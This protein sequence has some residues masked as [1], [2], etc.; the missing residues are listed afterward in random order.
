PEHARNKGETF[1][2]FL[3]SC[4]YNS[5]DLVN[6]ENQL[7]TFFELSFAFNA[8]SMPE[9][10][11]RKRGVDPEKARK[12]G[13]FNGLRLLGLN[14]AQ[15]E[16]LNEA[17][18]G[19]QTIEDAP[20]LKPEH[21]AVFDCANKC[22]KLGERFIATEGHIRMMAAAQPFVS[23]AISK[24]INLP[25][26][27]SVEDVASAYRLSWELGLKANALYRDGSKLSQPLSSK[28]DTEAEADEETAVEAA[29]GEASTEAAG[30]SATLM[31]STSSAFAT[32][33]LAPGMASPA[34]GR[35]SG[36]PDPQS[37][38][39]SPQSPSSPEPSYIERIIEKIVE[40][41]LRQRLPDTRRSI[42]HRF[43]VAGHE[44][45]LTVG[46]YDDGRPGE[47]FITMSKEG[48]TI[49]GLMDSLGTAIS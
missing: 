16:T 45:Y 29:L 17:I 26:E 10:V 1:R 46:L 6:L 20:H 40:R 28:S 33:I 34:P 39:L 2:A 13:S 27:A 15:I 41:P 36:L 11:L 5:E 19:T 12:D 49:G 8:W 21:E 43:N 4:G 7:P 37:S 48:S 38:V 30:A 25:A 23:G 22:G 3:E 14:N 9:S 35:M 42:T 44:G 47:L 18:C 31:S 24:T 32:S